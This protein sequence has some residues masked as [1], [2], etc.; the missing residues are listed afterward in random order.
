MKNLKATIFALLLTINGVGIYP[1]FQMGVLAQPPV[2]SESDSV[3][4][5]SRQKA[6]DHI[7]KA[8]ELFEFITDPYQ[9][10]WALSNISSAYVKAGQLDQALAVTQRISDSFDRL[11]ALR[12]L[13]P[14]YAKAGQFDQALALANQISDDNYK[15]SAMIEIAEAYGEAGKSSCTGSELSYADQIL[16]EA[17]AFADGISDPSVQSDFLMRI[18]T[19]YAKVGWDKDALMI[20]NRISNHE[21]SQIQPGTDIRSLA[22]SNIAATYTKSRRYDK[23]LEVVN[24]IS[25]LSEQSQA[26]IDL[27]EAY[28]K[29]GQLEKAD[30]ILLQALTKVNHI[31]A[32]MINIAEAYFK[33]G[34][35]EKADTILVQ[36]LALTDDFS[37]SSD[38]YRK[39]VDIARV[40]IKAGQLEKADTILVQALA[41]ANRIPNGKSDS[42]KSYVWALRDIALTYIE[43]GKT[44]K[45]DEILRQALTSANLIPRFEDDLIWLVNE[46]VSLHVKAGQFDQ[47][48][49]IVNGMSNPTEQFSAL[50]N[51]A[52]GYMETGQFAQAL[53]VARRVSDPD[54]ESF[55]LKGT[56]LAYAEAGQL[57]KADDVLRQALAV[58]QRISDPDT[59]SFVIASIAHAYA[60][61]GKDYQSV[62]N[63]INDPEIKLR[64]S[65]EFHLQ[66]A[67]N[68]LGN[69][70]LQNS[71]DSSCKHSHPG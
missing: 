7:N 48:L 16:L 65:T 14:A 23:A 30:Q 58:A 55:V 50:R 27:A 36:A 10:S 40:Y 51:I 59:E 46:I 12:E 45:V 4:T 1:P 39:S 70:E 3:T 61:V 15:F 57:E 35:L 62:L 6:I 18:A 68:I 60:D 34:Q 21:Y 64:V 24:G 5:S 47:A 20:A 2:E 66:R 56:A 32:I 17:L 49:M 31:S 13:A 63:L 9:Q 19:V 42:E 67:E 71:F 8:Y 44:E 54:T 53:A 22:L 38:S 25:D 41:E 26:M 52:F 29:V 69:L 43:A 11:L 33:A 37:S 28:V